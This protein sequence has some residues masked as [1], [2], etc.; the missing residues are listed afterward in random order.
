M[1]KYI[2]HGL[3]I[4]NLLATSYV[5]YNVSARIKP[6]EQLG[7]IHDN[8]LLQVVCLTQVTGIIDL[9]KCPK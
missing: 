7:K 8:V 3:L 1:K 5:W 4:A 9:E 6:V 2:I